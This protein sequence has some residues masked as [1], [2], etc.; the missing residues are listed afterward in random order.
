MGFPRKDILTLLAGSVL[1]WLAVRFL[2]PLIRPFLLGL[3]LALAAEPMVRFLE[4]RLRL[5]RQAAAGLGVSMAF[6]FLALLVTVLCAAAVRQL[7]SLAGI[8]PGLEEAARRALELTQTNLLALAARAPRNLR[9][10]LTEHL[11]LLF[12]DGSTLLGKITAW[13][14]GLAGGILGRLPDSALGFGTGILSAFLISARLPKIR[15]WLLGKIPRD[16]LAALQNRLKR[17]RRMLRSWLTAQLKLMSVTFCIL[18]AGLTLLRIP[19]SLLWA[20]VIAL[21][22]ALPVFGTG[23]VLIPWALVCFLQGNRVLALGIAGTYATA[24]LTRSILEPK[25]LGRH[26]G[27]D[28]LATLAAL[29]IGCRLW[30]IAGMIAAPMITVAL[31]QLRR[32]P[33][34]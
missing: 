23:T 24:A 20:F 5:P 25:L 26:L 31:L 12:S 30:G 22:D 21:V 17:L 8:L 7:R 27:L 29:Y 32:A 3:I 34:E 9:P 13:L 1:L 2:L 18:A 33:G 28:P 16:T 14:L 15:L 11:R 19:R 10:V 6:C 4:K